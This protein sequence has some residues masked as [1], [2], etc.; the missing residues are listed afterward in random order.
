MIKSPS[1]SDL[2]ITYFSIKYRFIILKLPLMSTVIYINMGQ[3]QSRAIDLERDY[4]QDDG[5]DL[6]LDQRQ[7]DK[8][9]QELD[10]G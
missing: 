2:H 8:M 1:Y 3:V 10:Q 6:E 5:M 4:R 9:D 7:A